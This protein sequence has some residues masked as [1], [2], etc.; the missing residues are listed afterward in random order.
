M[1]NI[2]FLT[3]QLTNLNVFNYRYAITC[4]DW[5]HR[6]QEDPEQRGNMY[7]QNLSAHTVCDAA[8]VKRMF[9]IAEENRINSSLL[10]N[11]ENR[12]HKIFIV[13]VYT[14]I[15]TLPGEERMKSGKLLFI[16]VAGCENLKRNGKVSRKGTSLNQ[17]LVTLTNVIRGLEERNS[18]IPYG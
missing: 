3:Q 7:I 1:S 17:S 8:D 18:Y 15:V 4:I 13:N 5:F 10:E 2:V 9:E 14:R 12:S 11:A 6:V 16:D